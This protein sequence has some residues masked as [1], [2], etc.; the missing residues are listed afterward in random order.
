GAADPAAG[1]SFPAR[2]ASDLHAQ[3]LGLP[4][5]RRVVV[6]D[7]LAERR[8]VVIDQKENLVGVP[9]ARYAFG[10]ARLHRELVYVHEVVVAHRPVDRKSTRLHSSHV[11]ISYA[12]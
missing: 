7:R 12:V 1:L 10:E 9:D 6:G 5:Y 2:R 8:L 11:K 3:P 4:A